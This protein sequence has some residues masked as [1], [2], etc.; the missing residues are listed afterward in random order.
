MTQGVIYSLLC[1]EERDKVLGSCGELR[2]IRAK[3]EHLEGCL[4]RRE[5][6]SRPIAQ[7]TSSPTTATSKL[8]TNSKFAIKHH[9][10]L[11]ELSSAS[12][13]Q[14]PCRTHVLGPAKRKT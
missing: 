6:Q 1:Y 12:S 2:A 4:R 13:F 14:E 10:G 9:R 5:T 7:C 11:P 3:L 8:P